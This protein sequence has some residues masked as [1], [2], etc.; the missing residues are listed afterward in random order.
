GKGGAPAGVADDAEIDKKEESLRDVLVRIYAAL[1]NVAAAAIL[2]KFKAQIDAP[3]PDA[4]TIVLEFLHDQSA[5]LADTHWAGLEKRLRMETLLFEKPVLATGKS[6]YP[7]ALRAAIIAQISAS[8]DEGFA[9]VRADIDTF[10]SKNYLA[11][12]HSGEG[13]VYGPALAAVQS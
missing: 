3:H 7:G 13:E 11:K 5:T 1:G 10:L 2:D 8:T 12:L 9:P 6:K 4:T